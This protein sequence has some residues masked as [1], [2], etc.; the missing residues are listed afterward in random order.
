MLYCYTF[1]RLIRSYFTSHN[2]YQYD[3]P[4]KANLSDTSNFRL[5]GLKARYRSKIYY[6]NFT[7]DLQTTSQIV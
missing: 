7:S 2:N 6:F 3:L 5:E 4:P 1:P